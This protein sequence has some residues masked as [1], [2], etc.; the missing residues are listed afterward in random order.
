MFHLPPKA[1]PKIAEKARRV[2]D[3]CVPKVTGTI[4]RGPLS[5]RHEEMK[6]SKRLSATLLIHDLEYLTIVV[7]H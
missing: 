7:N 2:T 4:Q 3:D 5:S 1:V 6:V